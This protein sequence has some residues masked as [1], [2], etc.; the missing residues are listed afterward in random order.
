MWKRPIF[1]CL[2]E[3][4]VIPT[5][6]GNFKKKAHDTGFLVTHMMMC[7]CNWRLLLLYWKHLLFFRSRNPNECEID[8]KQHKGTLCN[9]VCIWHVQSD[10]ICILCCFIW[11]L[12][13]AVLGA[14]S[15]NENNFFSNAVIYH[16]TALN[17]VITLQLCCYFRYRSSLVVWILHWVTAPTLAAWW[18]FFKSN[19]ILVSYKF[20]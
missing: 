8:V 17:Q 4:E 10:M 11:I 2:V 9:W 7:Y 13:H 18:I 15:N 16:V 20:I 3:H 6:G 12:L 14:K 19:F 1:L 5:T